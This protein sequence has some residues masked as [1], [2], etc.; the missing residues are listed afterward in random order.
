MI[1]DGVLD[2]VDEIYGIHV[3]PM[4]E[5][6]EIGIRKGAFLAR[7]DSFKVVVEGVG[8]HAAMPHKTADPIL[9]GAHLVTAL[10]SIVSRSVD[11]LEPAVVSV[12]EFHGGSCD[13]VIPAGVALTGTVRSFDS[14][15]TSTIRNRLDALLDGAAAS[16]G[17]DCSLEYTEG[18]PVTVNH[19]ACADKALEAARI[20][21]VPEKIIHPVP[22][23]M[24]GEDF[25]RYAQQ[26]PGCFIALGSGNAARGITR[27]LHHPGF[28]IDEGCLPIGAAL[29]AAIALGAAP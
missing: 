23:V 17:V 6:G 14:E 5:C 19:P 7:P 24:G 13:N 16:F 28:D 2:G 22:R 27:E 3:W 18:H 25:S 9:A 4:L 12:T 29:H 11:P 21:T 10:Q 8:G 20:A 1:E 26:V 15:V